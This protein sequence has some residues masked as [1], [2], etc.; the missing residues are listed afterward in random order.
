[1][2]CLCDLDK[3]KIEKQLEKI[4]LMVNQPR[5]ICRKCARA[6]N[7]EEFVCKPVPIEPASE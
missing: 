2:E 6:A 5:W 3:K 4:K 7:K 1:M